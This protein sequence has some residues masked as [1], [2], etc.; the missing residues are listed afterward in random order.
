VIRR[1]AGEIIP[2]RPNLGPEPWVDRP[3]GPGPLGLGLA[4]LGLALILAL[5]RWRFRRE[6]RPV[7]EVTGD[8]TA[9]VD[10]SPRRRVIA[11]SEAVRVALIAAFGPAW[12]SKTTE[13]IAADPELGGRLDPGRA[14]ELAAFLR[15]A[16]RAKFAG[17]EAAGA[18]EALAWASAFVAGLAASRPMASPST[19]RG[20][21]AASGRRSRRS[22][23]PPSGAGPA[24]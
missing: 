21:P 10:R 23:R 16:D 5:A 13:E 11:A 2:P 9:E 8:A 14:E 19:G 6:A 4:A 22:D 7:V 15:L 12:G 17:D 18:D 24:R 20:R 3:I 1:Q